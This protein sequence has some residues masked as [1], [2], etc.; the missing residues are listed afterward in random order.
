M[1]KAKYWDQKGYFVHKLIALSDEPVTERINDYMIDVY[2]L[3]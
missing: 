1:P 3:L 2:D